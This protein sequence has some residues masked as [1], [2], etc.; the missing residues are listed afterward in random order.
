MDNEISLIFILIPRIQVSNI[1][2]VIY[3]LHLFS[4]L[5]VKRMWTEYEIC[6]NEKCYQMIVTE[7]I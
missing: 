3:T 7:L 1:I 4:K 2:P 5:Y 6:I